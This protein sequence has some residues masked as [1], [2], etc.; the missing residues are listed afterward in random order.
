MRDGDVTTVYLQGELDLA[1]ASKVRRLIEGECARYPAKLVVDLSAV[2]FIDSSGL[3]LLVV[4]HRRLL[5]EGCL[6]VVASPSET[7]WRAFVVTN[8]DG[9]LLFEP[10]PVQAA[11]EAA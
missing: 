3:S 8:L 1:S 10:A 7:V 6:L 5:D 9:T 2:E 4:T 11:T